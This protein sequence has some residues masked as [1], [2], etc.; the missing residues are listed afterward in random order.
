MPESRRVLEEK[1]QRY[2]QLL[3]RKLDKV[4]QDCDDL[5]G[6]MAN[7]EE[8]RERGDRKMMEFLRGVIGEIKMVIG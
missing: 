1:G 4:K 3:T 5:K 6:D 2:D 8:K 7:Q